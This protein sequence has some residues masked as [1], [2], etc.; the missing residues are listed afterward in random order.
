M[1]KRLLRVAAIVPLVALALGASVPRDADAQGAVGSSPTNAENFGV[2]N[3][4][5]VALLKGGESRWFVATTSG[6][7]TRVAA[8]LQ[9]NPWLDSRGTRL[10]RGE[11]DIEPGAIAVYVNLRGASPTP[12]SNP[13][14]LGQDNK[15]WPGLIR[16]GHLTPTSN[17]GPD[18][19]YWF[20]RHNEIL[21]TFFKLVNNTKQDVVYA[22]TVDH[23]FCLGCA[24]RE[25]GSDNPKDW[26]L[27]PPPFAFA[28]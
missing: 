22:F 4:T 23:S 16:V 20:A 13:S 6:N 18:R 25:G 15:D 9:T 8:T 5:K 28:S 27:L 26:G 19:I 21:D 3:V 14:G 10:L 24:G 2:R 1:L 7:T 11:N 17:S 12:G